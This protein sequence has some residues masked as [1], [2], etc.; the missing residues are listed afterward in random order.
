MKSTVGQPLVQT[1]IDA[2]MRRLYGTGDRACELPHSRDASRRTPASASWPSMRS[3]KAWGPNYP[4]GWAPRVVKRLHRRD[5]LQRARRPSHDVVELARCR[6]PYRSAA[7]VQ[8]QPAGRV[9]PAAQRHGPVLHRPRGVAIEQERVNFYKGGDRFAVYKRRLAPCRA[10]PRH[11]VRPVRL[12]PARCR[13]RS[14]DTR[15]CGTGPSLID[16]SDVT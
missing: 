6:T 10:G 3:R 1:E 4:A 13:G 8:Q 7:G 9:L 14:A 16:P 5:L 2:D 15:G 12:D 11:P